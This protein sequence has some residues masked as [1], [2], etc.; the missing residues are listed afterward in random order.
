MTTPRH[1]CPYCGSASFAF[2]DRGTVEILSD[3]KVGFGNVLQP[4]ISLLICKGCGHTAWFMR[5]HAKTIAS[6]K[7]EV[8]AVPTGTYRG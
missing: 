8:R 1:P 7:H 6:V 4:E 3:A 5:D 2:L